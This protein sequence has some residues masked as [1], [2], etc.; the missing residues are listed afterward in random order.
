LAREPDLR[1]I[2]S[3]LEV[4]DPSA[5]VAKNDQGVEKLECG[6]CDNE[7]V[8]RGHVAHVVPQEGA[9]GRGGRFGSPRHIPTDGGL[10][11]FNA[12]FEQFAVDAGR[13]PDWVGH[14]HLADQ[15]PELCV[16]LRPTNPVRS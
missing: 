1:R 6:G 10:A 11:D 2:W 3:D 15:L 9:P 5:V 12:E 16:R 7:H 14:A 13:S 8:D 4:D